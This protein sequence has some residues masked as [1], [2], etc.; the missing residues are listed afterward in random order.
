VNPSYCHPAQL[1]E[2]PERF[3]DYWERIN[4]IDPRNRNREF[5][6][7]KKKK[8]SGKPKNRRSKK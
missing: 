6:P 5:R 1:V 7:S 2:L 8:K 4:V 3:P